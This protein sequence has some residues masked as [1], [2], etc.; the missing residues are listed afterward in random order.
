MSL[1]R[2]CTVPRKI[3]EIKS[4]ADQCKMCVSLG[5]GMAWQGRLKPFQ[6]PKVKFDSVI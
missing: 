6:S 4:L 5:L 1:N 2:D 3:K